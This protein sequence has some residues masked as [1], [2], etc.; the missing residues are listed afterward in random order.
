VQAAADD[1][2][3]TEGTV[4]FSGTTFADGESPEQVEWGAVAPGTRGL[5]RTL[6]RS[7]ESV[8]VTYVSIGTGVRPD[9][10]GERALA[11][12]TVAERYLDLVER[13]D[14]VTRELDLHL[15]G[16]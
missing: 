4:L 15:R 3:E 1:L 11:A 2:R 9:A 7:L 6:A 13:E 5:A 14:A 10:D 8:Q 12:G 16:Q